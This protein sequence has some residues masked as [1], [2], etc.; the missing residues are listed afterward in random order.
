M[1]EQQKKKIKKNDRA[2]GCRSHL[3]RSGP[4][5]YLTALAG[6]RNIFMCRLVYM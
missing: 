4:T 2:A 5:V 3:V 6:P 1:I